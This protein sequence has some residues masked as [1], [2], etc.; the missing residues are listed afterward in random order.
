M[1][2]YLPPVGDPAAAFLAAPDFDAD[3]STDF[4]DWRTFMLNGLRV[5]H[6]LPNANYNR[7]VERGSMGTPTARRVGR[8][9]LFRD[10]VALRWT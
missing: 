5:S 10:R 1:A 3:R 7:G 6:R 9:N 4:V 8:E 2:E